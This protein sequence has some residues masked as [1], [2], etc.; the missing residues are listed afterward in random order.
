V[1][2]PSKE[3]AFSSGGSSETL[4]APATPAEATARSPGATRSTR[5]PIVEYRDG[6]RLTS[7][8]AP[9]SGE[10]AR[11]I[12]VQLP[13]KSSDVLFRIAS[14]E[15]TQELGRGGMGSV[16]RAYS[17]KLFRFVAI[18]VF[19][20]RRTASE[21]DLI[22]FHNE[23][24]LTARLK[25]RNIV[26]VYDSGEDQG[27]QY[28]VMELMEG[29]SLAPLLENRDRELPRQIVP[30]VVKVARALHFAHQKGIVHRDIKPDNILLDGEGEPAIGDFG[31]AKSL[32]ESPGLT[33]EGRA[34]GTPFYMPP[35]Q[36]NGELL[37]IGPH[38]DVYALGATLYHLLCGRPPFSGPNEFVLLANIVNKEAPSPAKIALETMGR[39]IPVDLETI[40]LK[41]MEK[42]AAKRYASAAAFAD[43]LQR[44]LDGQAI[45]ARPVGML[46]RTQ[47]A[48][49]RNRSAMLAALATLLVLIVL[50]AAFGALSIDSVARN[51][52]TLSQKALHDALDQAATLERAIRVNMLQG[53]ADLSRA[54]MQQLNT[55]PDSGQVQVVRTDR[56]VA[57]TDPETRKRVQQYLADPGVLE[58]IRRDAPDM[59]PAIDVLRTVA[60]PSIDRHTKSPELVQV[61]KEAWSQ[62]LL[63]G[64]PQHY[65]EDRSGTPWM[66]VLWPIESSSEC[67]TCHGGGERE[68]YAVRDPVRAVVVIRRSNAD[69]AR[70]LKENRAATIRVGAITA[71]ALLGLMVLFSRVLGMRPKPPQFGVG[72]GNRGEDSK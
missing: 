38:S 33:R 31:I 35:E 6:V 57:Y 43:D 29:G 8:G 24:M 56:Q 45:Q 67:R 27:Q 19:A 59:L 42:E 30:I 46:E 11:S 4:T 2:T 12:K 13:Y 50:V 1:D 18:K 61:D 20:P 14:H 25:H 15:V 7:S 32:E 23:I 9:I 55:N 68:P 41:A 39:T 16:Y 48:L 47:K 72:I 69:L 37:H 63:T 53:R 22:R 28:F 17:L 64:K 52:R 44:F 60:F 71:G 49:Q 26:P 21:I 58:R 51:D 65:T 66:V 3:G 34:I 40:C 5:D 54:L 70:T 62:T 36:A 10:T